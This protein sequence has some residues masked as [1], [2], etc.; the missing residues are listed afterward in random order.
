LPVKTVE[1]L[2]AKTSSVYEEACQEKKGPPFAKN[3]FLAM[4]PGLLIYV[5][6]SD[7]TGIYSFSISN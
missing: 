3:S 7:A 4:R 2:S 6:V 1:E 5:F